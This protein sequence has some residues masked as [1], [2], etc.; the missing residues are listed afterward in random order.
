MTDRN[1]EETEDVTKLSRRD[2]VKTGSALFGVNSMTEMV[3]AA[4]FSA[5]VDFKGAYIGPDAD[6]TGIGAKGWLYFADD[7]GGRYKHDG[8]SWRLL[9]LEAK[10]ISTGEIN[11]EY[12]IKSSDGES[13]VR[14]V[15][16]NATYGDKVVLP[17]KSPVARL[18]S[19][20]TIP[21]GVMVEHAAKQKDKTGATFVKEFNGPAVEYN[22]WVTLRNVRVDGNRGSGFT[23]DGI[24]PQSANNR[25]VYFQEV[26]SRRNE[27][28]GF[29]VNKTFLSTFDACDFSY[30]QDGVSLQGA[31]HSPHTE[32]R[33]CR[34][35]Y[36][37]RAGYDIAGGS[38]TDAQKFHACLIDQNKYGVDTE[39]AS[40]GRAWDAVLSGGT[41]IQRND[42]PGI[43]LRGT[44]ADEVVLKINAG[45][46][47]GDNNKNT[48]GT[49]TATNGQGDVHSEGGRISGF[50]NGSV[51]EAH[52]YNS[53]GVSTS[54]TING[55]TGD[56]EVPD[57]YVTVSN[58]EEVGAV[59][60]LSGIALDPTGGGS[61]VSL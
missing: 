39:R 30:N 14:A 33:H 27:G 42:G 29:V 28:A 36:N 45:S 38:S 53:D 55:S 54:L 4:E 57:T 2:F 13:E 49:L 61:T 48:D 25:E 8:S 40:V 11:N 58:Y 26:T 34:M 51:W 18:S 37:D 12:R 9:D 59:T 17:P 15:I 32:W 24:V 46:F 50:I 10:S 6:K 23:G 20:L 31:N 44:D 52:R 41:I 1:S 21:A 16:E 56:I 7:T 60:C 47:I 22:D 5:P 35:A 43:L 19:T 3:S